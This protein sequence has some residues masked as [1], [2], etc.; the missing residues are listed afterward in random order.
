[1]CYIYI[2][3]FQKTK[4]NNLQSDKEVDIKIHMEMECQRQ[5]GLNTNVQIGGL[6]ILFKF[7]NAYLRK[8]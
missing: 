8:Y 6:H 1:M 5:R 2:L 7:Y 3:S 4:H